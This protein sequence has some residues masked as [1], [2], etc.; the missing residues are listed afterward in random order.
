MIRHGEA[1]FLECSTRGDARF[2][3]FRARPRSAGGQSIEQVYQNAK[4]LADGRTNQGSAAKGKRATNAAEC[5][6]LYSRLWDEYISE[7]PELFEVI[8]TAR[9]LS[10][11]FGQPGHACQATEL[12]RIRNTFCACC[13][14]P[15]VDCTCPDSPDPCDA[16]FACSAHCRCWRR[17]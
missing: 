7:N 16:C 12:W 9:G 10:D 13:V 6:A 15:L 2:S 14:R 5:A 8:R 1:P 3:A 4:V 11:M 17:V